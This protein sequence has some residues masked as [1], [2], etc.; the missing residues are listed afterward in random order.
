[1]DGF[2]GTRVLMLQLSQQGAIGSRNGGQIKTS[3]FISSS[4]CKPPSLLLLKG[5][6]AE[7]AAPSCF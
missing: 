1:M 7:W 6:G 4:P 2:V 3:S 5:K